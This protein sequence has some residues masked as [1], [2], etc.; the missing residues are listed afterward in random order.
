MH[1][2]F[3]DAIALTGFATAALHIEG[4]AAGFV[5][6]CFGLWQF[7]EPVPDRGEQVRI[8]GGVGARGTSDG[9]LVDLDDLVEIVHAFQPVIG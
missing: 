8:G 2:D 6:A 4:E 9:G 5:T 3:Q 7:S 1:F